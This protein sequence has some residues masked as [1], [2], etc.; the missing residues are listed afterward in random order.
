MT[1]AFLHEYLVKFILT[2]DIVGADLSVCPQEVRKCSVPTRH[3]Y[4]DR[5]LETVRF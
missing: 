3:N 1:L 2:N 4:L 5:V